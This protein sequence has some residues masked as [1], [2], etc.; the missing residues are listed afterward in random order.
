[1]RNIVTYK[2]KDK[3]THTHTLAKP[4]NI[5]NQT[6]NIIIIITLIQK[7]KNNQ[8]RLIT[9]TSLYDSSHT[10]TQPSFLLSIHSHPYIAPFLHDEQSREITTRLYTFAGNLLNPSLFI[11]ISLLSQISNK[12]ETNKKTI[13]NI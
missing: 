6:Q 2:N 10:H 11:H 9:C 1:M 5:K 8:I 13:Q 4:L 12:Q 7:S 3:N